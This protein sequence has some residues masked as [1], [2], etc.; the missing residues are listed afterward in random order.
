LFWGL[1]SE[2]LCAYRLLLL[3]WLNHFCPYTDLWES[4][5]AGVDE[6]GRKFKLV[7]IIWPSWLR[8]GEAWLPSSCASKGIE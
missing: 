8:R 3:V 1:S 4:F 6:K 5:C 2:A 7:V